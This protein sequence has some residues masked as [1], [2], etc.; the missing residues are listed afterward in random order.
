MFSTLLALLLLAQDA[1]P[2]PELKP[3]LAELQK[4]LRSAR[5]LLSQYTYTEKET[6]IHLDSNRQPRKT[7]VK[8]YEV[9]SWHR[10]KAP[11]AG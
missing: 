3:F 8:I 5:S 9:F 7:E 1:R 10:I 11:T 2:L 6:T 4:T